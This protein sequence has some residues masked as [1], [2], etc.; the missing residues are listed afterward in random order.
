MVVCSVAFEDIRHISS[1]A[2]FIGI[3]LPGT[4][5]PSITVFNMYLA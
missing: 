4:V 3:V 5:I 1:G 2:Q